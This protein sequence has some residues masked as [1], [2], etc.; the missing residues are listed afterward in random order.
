MGRGGGDWHHGILPR[1][2]LTPSVLLRIV[3]PCR[4]GMRGWGL[5]EPRPRAPAGRPGF[6]RVWN[7]SALIDRL[8]CVSRARG[9][10]PGRARRGAC[11]ERFLLRPPGGDPAATAYFCLRSVARRSRR[12]TTRGWLGPRS[13]SLR[14]V[15]ARLLFRWS[16]E[17]D[18]Q[19]LG[20]AYEIFVGCID[21]VSQA[22]RDGADQEIDVTALH[23]LGSAG[24]E[25]ARG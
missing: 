5:A 12:V 21:V 3:L 1:W 25:L 17:A 9:L 24:V 16:I 8:S 14:A 22:G 18:G 2:G 6:H 11:H 20:E 7:E 4:T 19:V 13:G 15:G 10:V 23:A